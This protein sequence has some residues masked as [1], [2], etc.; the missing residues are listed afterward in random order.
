MICAAALLATTVTANPIIGG[1]LET[2][3]DAVVLV[4]NSALQGCTGTL[5][6]ETVVLTAAHCVAVIA[7]GNDPKFVWAVDDYFETGVEW[8]RGIAEWHASPLWDPAIFMHHDVGVVILDSPA[9]VKPYRWLAEDSEGIYSQGSSFTQIGIGSTYLGGLG[10]TKMSAEFTMSVVQPTLFEFGSLGRTACYGDS[11]GP[12]LRN[13]GGY[14]TVV[15]V[16]SFVDTECDDRSGN[17][18]TDANAAFISQYASPTAGTAKSGSDDGGN[19]F[20][21]AIAGTTSPSLVLLAPLILLRLRHRP[22]PR[23]DNEY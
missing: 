9:P 5:I 1:Q 2:K 12:A 4:L 15:G 23:R 10:G 22:R 7:S 13:I 6:D 11:G 19:A 16:L 18:R 8:E 17:G 21:C 20:G 14:V 3:H